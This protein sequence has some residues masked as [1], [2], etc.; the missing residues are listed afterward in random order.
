MAANRI[1]MLE[2][3][4]LKL[5]ASPAE[6]SPTPSASNITAP[7][8]GSAGLMAPANS[9]AGM[10]Q[11]AAA[12]QAARIESARQADIARQAPLS[13]VPRTARANR[14]VAGGFTPGP[15]VGALVDD[16][17]KESLKTPAVRKTKSTQ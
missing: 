2:M 16:L 12:V 10:A 3:S 8:F 11:A 14:R 1:G 17:H 7:T 4:G 9:A 5:V 13:D 6:R 15:S